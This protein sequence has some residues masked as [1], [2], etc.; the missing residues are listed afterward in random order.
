MKKADGV[1]AKYK[2]QLDAKK[3][4][5][6]QE[7]MAAAQ[8]SLAVAYGVI[9]EAKVCEMILAKMSADKLKKAIET[10]LIRLG[11]HSKLWNVNIKAGRHKALRMEM[12]SIILGA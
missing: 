11:K 6:F 3:V 7:S 4:T 8:K 12:D 1:I 2:S 5:H 9:T 10:E